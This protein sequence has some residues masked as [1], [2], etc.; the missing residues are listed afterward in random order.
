MWFVVISVVDPNQTV[1]ARYVPVNL[2]YNS[3]AY[4]SYGLGIVEKPNMTV[5]VRVTGDGSVVG[6]LEAGDFAGVPGLF[7][8]HGRKLPTTLRLIVRRA[9]TPLP[10]SSKGN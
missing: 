4:E 1:N 6:G 7:Q 5:N 9:D 8:R 3:A 10:P 2:E